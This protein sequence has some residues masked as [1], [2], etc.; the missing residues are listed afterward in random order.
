M[1]ILEFHIGSLSLELKAPLRTARTEYRVRQGAVIELT[2]GRERGWGEA[3][4]L[5]SFG[6]ESLDECLRILAEAA[7]AIVGEVLPEEP[8]DIDALLATQRALTAA[9]AARH[10]VE[11]ALLDLA[12][13]RR[14]VP[15]R[16]LLSPAARDS[17]SVATLVASMDPDA[18]REQAKAAALAG[19]RTLKLKVAAA[20]V[21]VDLRRLESARAGAG[22]GVRIRIDANGGWNEREALGNL[23]RLAG[24]GLEVC[25]QPLPVG[26]VA[27]MRELRGTVPCAI[28]ADESVGSAADAQRLLEPSPAVD[29]LVLKPMVVGGL[30]RSL[31]IARRAAARGVGSYVSSSLDGVVARGAAAQLAAALPSADWASGLAV[32]GLFRQEPR[33]HPMEPRNGRIAL[34]GAPGLG[35]VGSAP[36][37]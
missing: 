23:R 20:P 29:V 14:R 25:E 35:F 17:V 3:M 4:P 9:P 26:A 12:A 24:V 7:S 16:S 31:E 33:H 15:L 11:S 18:V 30:W 22:P 8:R 6:T 36:C 5:P 28:A 19:F 37:A 2:D 21:E 10:A 27:A 13:R 34:S 32:G 1:R